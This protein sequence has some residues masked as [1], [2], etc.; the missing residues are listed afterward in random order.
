MR[1]AGCCRPH[2]EDMKEGKKRIFCLLAACL[3]AV[4]L[5]GCSIEFSNGI[6]PNGNS[7][8]EEQNAIPSGAAVAEEGSK[9]E[10][11]DFTL[12]IPDGMKWGTL[13]TDTGNAYYVWDKDKEYVLPTDSDIMLYIYE[14]KDTASPDSELTSRE[15]RYS[16]AQTY[17]QIFRESVDGKISADPDIVSNDDW[18]VL[19]LTGYSGDSMAT[20]YG[21]YCYPN[22]YYGVY[23]LQ[24]TTDTYNR[25]YYGF[26]FGNDSTGALLEEEDYNDLYGQIKSAFSIT[27]F[28][29]APQLEYDESKDY[30]NG[31]SYA[32]LTELFSGTA[33]YY[34][35]KAQD[36]TVNEA[37]QG[38]LAGAYEVV[39]VVDGDTI[40][41][42]IDGTE[43]KIRLIGVDTP[44]S[45]S[46]DEEKNTEEGKQAS[47]YTTEQLTG[48][49]VYLEYDEGLTDTYGRTLAYVYLDDMKTMYNKVLLQEGYA[50]VMT[51][52]PNTKYAAD[53]ETL[54][55]AAK[56][57]GKGFWGTGFFESGE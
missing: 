48:K 44:E 15:A 41:V 12:T 45:V 34:G 25:N 13:T 26:V 29:T 39:R 54:E 32:Q 19:Q 37:E 17:M 24:K 1:A 35:M 16:I 51:V 3:L 49:S 21:T 55:A 11:S 6:F 18:Y 47:E 33:N 2:G 31:Y 53:F 36:V 27:E 8:E 10:L 52:E 50:K 38:T 22:Y 42:N 9:I 56:E 7:E 4:V 57:A 40:I 14:G 28:Y 20:S 23:V 30:S 5:S 46:T 43:T